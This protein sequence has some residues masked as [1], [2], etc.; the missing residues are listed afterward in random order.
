[1]HE[2]ARQIN[3]AIAQSGQ[4]LRMSDEQKQSNA[5]TWIFESAILNMLRVEGHRGG[6][7]AA[8][9]AVELAQVM[10]QRR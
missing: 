5:D 1:M 7:Q 8:Q 10:M 3:D 6:H 9:Q 4:L 2:R